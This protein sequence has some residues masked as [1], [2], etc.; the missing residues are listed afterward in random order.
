[1]GCAG[2]LLAVVVTVLIVAVV[3]VMGLRGGVV[4]S[5]RHAKAGCRRRESLQ[6]DEQRESEGEDEARESGRHRDGF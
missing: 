1:M 6:R 2:L 4:V 5:E 3:A